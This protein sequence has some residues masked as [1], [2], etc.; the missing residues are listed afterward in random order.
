M[1]G[2]NAPIYADPKHNFGMILAL[3]GYGIRTY[4][5]YKHFIKTSILK[6]GHLKM[7]VSTEEIKSIFCIKCPL[8]YVY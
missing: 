4:V 3:K 6:T 5:K 8:Y 1:I 7:D 2:D